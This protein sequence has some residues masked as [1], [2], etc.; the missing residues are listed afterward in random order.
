M[1]HDP[2]ISQS[3]LRYTILHTLGPAGLGVVY[4]AEHSH[5]GRRVDLTSLLL[6][7]CGQL[8]TLDC[9]VAQTSSGEIVLGSASEEGHNHVFGNDL[10]SPGTAVGSVA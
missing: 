9:G 8:K 1:N 4:D 2:L 7:D 6:T 5:H 3:L 10:T